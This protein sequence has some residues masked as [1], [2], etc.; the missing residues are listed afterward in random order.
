MEPCSIDF[1]KR[2]KTHSNLFISWN[3][4]FWFLING[5]KVLTLC[6]MNK[7]I[8]AQQLYSTPKQI[9]ISI[10]REATSM[11]SQWN[12]RWLSESLLWVHLLGVLGVLVFQE[13]LVYSCVSGESCVFLRLSARESQN[14]QVSNKTQHSPHLRM[15]T[16]GYLRRKGDGQTPHLQNTMRQSIRICVRL[17]LTRGVQMFLEIRSSDIEIVG[18]VSTWSRGVVL[19]KPRAVTSAPPT[20][21]PR[22]FP[23]ANAVKWNVG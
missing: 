4:P 7:N 3:R 14:N 13:S 22:K 2:E 18:T 16:S 10:S 9:S 23:S 8:L 17:P 21:G 15:K 1:A 5:G 20:V 6:E 12:L 19:V 11:I